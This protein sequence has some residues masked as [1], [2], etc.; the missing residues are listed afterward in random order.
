MTERLNRWFG[1]LGNNAA[2]LQSKTLRG[3]GTYQLL[4]SNLGTRGRRPARA[5]TVTRTLSMESP[6]LT[7]TLAPFLPKTR[8]ILGVSECRSQAEI[9]GNPDCAA[10][11]EDRCLGS[12][13][14]GFSP[15]RLAAQRRDC[16][17]LPDVVAWH[18]RHPTSS[19]SRGSVCTKL[20]GTCSGEVQGLVLPAWQQMA[21]QVVVV[22]QR[23]NHLSVDLV[24]ILL[25]GVVALDNCTPSKPRFYTLNIHTLHTLGLGCRTGQLHP[26]NGATLPH[27]TYL[28]LG[29]STGQVHPH[30][31]ATSPHFT[32]PLQLA[33]PVQHSTLLLSRTPTLAFMPGVKQRPGSTLNVATDVNA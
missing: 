24:H 33:L 13:F 21:V 32:L 31:R 19:P 22:H 2:A 10:G 9:P 5:T 3:L 7:P 25:A 15:L 26:H 28:G 1:R 14:S 11:Q 17:S 30:T 4:C 20:K 23:F 18:C 6:H 27:V 8:A 16:L 12:L 29:R